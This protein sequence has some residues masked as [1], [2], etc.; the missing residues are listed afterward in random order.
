MNVG[1]IKLK[2]TGEYVDLEGAL[3]VT[4]S[5]TYSMQVQGKVF[6]CESENKPTE[7]GFYYSTLKPFTFKRGDGKLW[8]YV[9]SEQANINIAR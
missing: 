8:V 4:L 3:G 6:L 1:Y 7:G 5:G 9:E 2:H